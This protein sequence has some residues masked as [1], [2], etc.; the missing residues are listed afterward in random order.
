MFYYKIKFPNYIQL[1]ED[2]NAY[3]I[4]E[5]MI[6]TIVYNPDT[7]SYEEKSDSFGIY[8]HKSIE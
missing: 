1:C 6:I 8:Y 3:H 5:D 4:L 7:S 2:L